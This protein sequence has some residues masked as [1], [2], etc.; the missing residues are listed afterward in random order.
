MLSWSV[1][2]R[3][4]LALPAQPCRPDGDERRSSL[5][6]RQGTMLERIIS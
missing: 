5:A 6:N 1:L 3:A 4:T 2:E